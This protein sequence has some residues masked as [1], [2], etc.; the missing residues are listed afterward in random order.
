MTLPGPI[1]G[2]VA[3]DLA[4]MC[5]WSENDASYVVNQLLRFALSQSEDFQEHKRL[6]GKSLVT[7]KQTSQADR[8][9]IAPSRAARTEA[10]P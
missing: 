7:D 6:A 2:T 3:D 1:V 8:R 10:E 5:E 4:L 9:A